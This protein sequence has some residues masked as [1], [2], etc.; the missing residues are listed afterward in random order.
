LDTKQKLA[1]LELRPSKRLGQNY[2]HDEQQI[3]KIIRFANLS[4]QDVVL[5]IGPGL[6]ALSDRL[7][8]IVGQLVLV[9]I[10]G[11][12]AEHLSKRFTG[13]ANVSIFHG[14][15]LNLHPEVFGMSNGGRAVVVSNAPYSISSPLFLWIVE[16]R[17]YFRAASLLFQKEFAE[18][19]AAEP[20]SKAY[21]SITV[22]ASTFG[23]TSL[24]P[25]VS[26]ESFYPVP[27]VE[28]QLLKFEFF[29]KPLLEATQI[30]SFEKL[31][32]SSFATR[33]K[34]LVNNLFNAGF[35]GSKEDAQKLLESLGIDPKAR[36]ENLSPEQFRELW[37]KISG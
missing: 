18:R 10:D 22:Y 17:E 26:A 9:E 25:T 12:A 27:E 1:Q 28:S 35:C 29:E 4:A 32:R 37:F 6:G 8:N 2:L 13:A 5:E 23:K 16:H 20:H 31:V 33:R 7:A 19:L 21:G 11:R 3:D 36:A 14:D 15:I 24:G 34:T 30:E